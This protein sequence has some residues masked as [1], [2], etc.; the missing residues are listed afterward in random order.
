METSWNVYDYPE[1]DNNE[2]ERTIKICGTF[3]TYITVETGKCNSREEE[4]D[5]LE[6]IVNQM[7]ERDLLR[8]CDKITIEE[9]EEV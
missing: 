8:E 7:D 4:Y 6:E 2:I 3:E 1:E 5:M 9:F